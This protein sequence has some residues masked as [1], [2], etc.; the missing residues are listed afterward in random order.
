[1][2]SHEHF[3]SFIIFQMI[4]MSFWY[5]D[6]VLLFAHNTSESTFLSDCIKK[7]DFNLNI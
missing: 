1:M 7:E 5:F 6:I 4:N 2:F 3:V